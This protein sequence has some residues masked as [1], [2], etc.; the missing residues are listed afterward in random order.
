MPVNLSNSTAEDLFQRALDSLENRQ[1]QQCIALIQSAME[2]DRQEG[3][4]SSRMKYLSYLGLALTLSLGRSEEGQKM[5]EQ[6]ASREFYDADLFCN[7][8]I[9]SLRNRRKKLAFD[10][11]RK[12]LTLK[13]RHRRIL[14]EL[15]RYERR[16]APVFSALPRQHFLNVVAGRLRMAGSGARSGATPS[17]T[18]DPIPRRHAPAPPASLPHCSA[19]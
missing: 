17:P 12:G 7:L 8:G 4:P 13:P 10:A 15:E 14:E 5:C 1:Y 3:S 19:A 18:T 6:A 16:E 9:V 2:L 11:F